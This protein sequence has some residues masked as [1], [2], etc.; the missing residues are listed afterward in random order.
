MNKLRI[1]WVV[2]VAPVGVRRNICRILIWILKGKG[3]TSQVTVRTWKGDI[4]VSGT[5]WPKTKRWTLLVWSPVKTHMR[6]SHNRGLRLYQTTKCFSQ[7]VRTGWFKR[8]A[9]PVNIFCQAVRTGWFKRPAVLVNI[10]CQ[11]EWTGWFKRPAVPVNIFCQAVWTG[12]FKRPA[13]LADIFCQVVCGV[14]WVVQQTSC[15][16]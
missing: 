5:L 14:N 9:V 11:V 15:P 3:P 8:P 6:W 1:R 10:F 2:H 4:K 16:G 13:V 7:V 12:W